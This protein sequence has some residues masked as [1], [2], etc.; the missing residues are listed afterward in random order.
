M[1]VELFSTCLTMCLP[2]AFGHHGVGPA[3]RLRPDR[4]A[5]AFPDRVM[6]VAVTD[7][8]V[9]DLV[10]DRVNNLILTVALDEV[11]GKFDPALIVDAQA[12]R[13]LPPIERKGPARQAVFAKKLLGKHA[14]IV[15][16]LLPGGWI[17]RTEL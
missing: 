10:K 15:E 4:D 9:R 3:N 5:L 6:T 11:G 12:H 7:E 16:E 2:A 17:G 8:S 1:P 13:P 14:D